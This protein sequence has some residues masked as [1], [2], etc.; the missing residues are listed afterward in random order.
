ML[1]D[2]WFIKANKMLGGNESVSNEEKG[3]N[4]ASLLNETRLRKRA[5]VEMREDFGYQ[6]IPIHKDIAIFK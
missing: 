1:T 2:R 3:H 6:E 5:K 4:D